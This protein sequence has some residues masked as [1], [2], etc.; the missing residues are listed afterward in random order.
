MQQHCNKAQNTVPRVE[1]KEFITSQVQA[2][3]AA[4]QCDH[5]NTKPASQSDYKV[6]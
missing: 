3:G 5:T 2:K 6:K 1:N 4:K